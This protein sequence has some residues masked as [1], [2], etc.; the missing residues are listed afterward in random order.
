[1]LT[2]VTFLRAITMCSAF[3]PDC[4][5]DNSN[6]IPIGDVYCPNTKCLGELCLHR[7]TF[8]SLGRSD[9]QC[10]QCGSVCQVRTIP[11]E[12]QINSFFLSL[13]Q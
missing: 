3:T 11:F 5:H 6:I 7:K 13:G 8:E 4:G 12:E 2:S 9:S 10:P 1:M